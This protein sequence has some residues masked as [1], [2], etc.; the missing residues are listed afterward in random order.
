[1]EKGPALERTQTFL[2]LSIVVTV[3]L[4]LVPYGRTIG[5]PLVLL[6]TLAHEMGHGIAAIFIGG[7]FDEFRMWSDGSGVARWLGS[8]VG[9]FGRAFVAAGGL[10]GPAVAAAV[11]FWLA[12]SERRARAGLWV[13]G[14]GLLVALV[15]VVRGVFGMFFV[16]AF[17]VLCI[18]LAAKAK[19]WLGQVTVVFIA[20]QMALS[21]FSRGDYLFTDKAQ[22]SAGP[23]PSDVAQMADA[24]WLPYWFWGA[25][26]GAVS[27]VVILV[28]LRA[29]FKGTQNK[30]AVPAGV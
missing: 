11:G 5:Y 30:A 24:L 12:R 15:L 22:T 28:G 2:V 7:H 6:S 13:F 10:V 23:M 16:S 27:V 25:L 9:R 8:D 14:V 17:A 20:V 19:P 26:C 21:V 4:Y 29:F 18:F 1:M 3:V